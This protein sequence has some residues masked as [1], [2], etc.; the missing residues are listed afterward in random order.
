MWAVLRAQSLGGRRARET[1]DNL[2]G[3]A[4]REPRRALRV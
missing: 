4:K 3:T 1:R 2:P